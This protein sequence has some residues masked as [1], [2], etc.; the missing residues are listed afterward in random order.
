MGKQEGF[1][2]RRDEESRRSLCIREMSSMFLFPSFSHFPLLHPASRLCSA[3]PGL[4]NTD[5]PQ[6][7]TAGWGRDLKP[8]RSGLTHLNLGP[9]DNNWGL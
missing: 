1:G 8:L 5:I 9:S 3:S 6:E 2:S 7:G 4:T